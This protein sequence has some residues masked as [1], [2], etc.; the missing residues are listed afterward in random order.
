[1]EHAL[2]Q[3]GER[4]IEYIGSSLRCVKFTTQIIN[5]YNY[6]D[7]YNRMLELLSMCLYVAL[8]P[9]NE[10]VDL[11]GA[12]AE[13]QASHVAHVAA[14]AELR[15]GARGGGGTLAPRH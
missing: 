15:C 4:H 14:Q 11:R 12:L 1:M 6:G 13:A 3:G 2:R 5:I 8:A 7:I 9:R 10:L